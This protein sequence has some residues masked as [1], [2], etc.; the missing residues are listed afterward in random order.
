MTDLF[1]ELE[2]RGFVHHATPGLK[3]HL[4]KGPVSAYCGFDP[5]APSL[6]LG[7]L[8]PIMLL[9]QLQRAG[10]RP[11]AVMGG[12]TGLI[13]DPSGKRAERPLLTPQQITEHVQRMR[14]QMAQFLDF[15]PG[16][17]AAL[18]VDNAKWLVPQKL[19]D[20][21]R[22]IGKHFTVNVMLQ[23]E[24]V[25]ARLEGGLSY[26]E[27]SYMLL[28]AYDYLH[29]YRKERCTLQV[30]GS[31]QWGNITA[32]VDL[33][34]RLENGEAHGLVAPLVT[35]AAGAKFGKSDAGAAI[36]LDPALT[37][38]YR[39]YQF[40]VNVDDRDVESYLKLF[41]LKPREEIKQLLSE[42][43]KNPGA[44]TAQR[45][46]ARDVTERVHGEAARNAMVASEILFGDFDPRN[47]SGSV[48]ATLAQEIPTASVSNNDAL[49]LIDA[50]VHAGL[51]TSKGEARRAIDQ[52]GVYVNQQRITAV[53]KRIDPSDWLAD[54]HLLLR[55]GKKEYALLRRS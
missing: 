11:I 38:P 2:W 8:M 15:D 12:G 16:P 52:G 31:D 39:F 36:Y 29:L 44:R 27:F 50:V 13:G 14:D 30:G 53:D 28:Q 4:A 40:W 10:H 47:A 19:V 24:S 46:L 25:Q 43:K 51:A 34:R 45:E 1:A 55:K 48:F 9:L 5:T 23:K 33:I 21:L 20:F 3:A 49:T 6:Q 17:A 54:G 41:T 18:L 35:T 26:T 22:D 7:N 32:G 37:S 42:Q